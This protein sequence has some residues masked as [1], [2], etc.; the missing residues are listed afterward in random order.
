MF[1]YINHS[2][3]CGIYA[4]LIQSRIFQGSA[5]HLTSVYPWEPVGDATLSLTT[6]SPISAAVSTSVHVYAP[7]Y[8]TVGLKYP[9]WRGIDVKP[10]TYVGSFWV[11]GLHYGNFTSSLGSALMGE[12]WAT[13]QVNGC[14]MAGHSTTF[15]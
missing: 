3:D 4:E 7:G 14:P 10:Q 12:L 9:G 15:P 13:T 5:Q 2:G 11:Y 1:E 6:A 8:S